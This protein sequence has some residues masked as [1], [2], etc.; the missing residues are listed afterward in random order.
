MAKDGKAELAS[1]VL[2]EKNAMQNAVDISFETVTVSQPVLIENHTDFDTD[3]DAEAVR[4]RA[5]DNL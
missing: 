5:I 3:F 4:R 1:V 2:I